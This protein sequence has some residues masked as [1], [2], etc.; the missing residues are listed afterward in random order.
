MARTVS[1]LRCLLISPG[2]VD[3]ERAAVSE[4]VDRWNAQVG[5]SLGARVNLVRWETH[6]VPDASG[7]PQHVLNR[8]IVDGCDFGI[9]VFWGRLGSPTASQPS[10]SVEE[11]ERLRA[12]GARVLIYFSTKDIAQAALRDDQFKRLQAFKQKMQREGLLGAYGSISHLRE[13]VQ[14]HL[15]SVVAELLERQRG[16]PVPG[17]ANEFVE[18]AHR[19]RDERYSRILSGEPMVMRGPGLCVF[20]LIPASAFTP[21]VHLDVTSVYSTGLLQPL[22][23]SGANPRYTID[24]ILAA[25]DDTYSMLYDTGIVETASRRLV[26]DPNQRLA[27]PSQVGKSSIVAAQ[28]AQAC[29]G[30]F[31]R[32]V[33][34]AKILGIVPPVLGMAMLSGVRDVPLLVP[35]VSHGLGAFFDTGRIDRDVVHLPEALVESFDVTPHEALRPILHG[36]WRAGGYPRCDLYDQNEIWAPNR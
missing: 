10:G 21:G 19:F 35:A 30:V 36:L 16:Q 12:R 34:A 26:G 33:K 25:G 32:Y 23:P 27:I 29:F 17:T 31:D 15:T 2:D 28:V 6:S 24:G 14:L 3:A 7:A 1:E 22:Y 13:Q 18:R 20:H 5:E 4:V 8:Q 11:I 9:A